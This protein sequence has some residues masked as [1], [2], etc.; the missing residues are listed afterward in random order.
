M[1]TRHYKLMSFTL[2]SNT[3]SHYH[4]KSHSA[5]KQNCKDFKAR[6]E[7]FF[8]KKVQFSSEHF[9]E[10]LGKHCLARNVFF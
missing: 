9:L 8:L 3:T 5:V 2:I 7:A 10:F 6:I 1:W 4:Q